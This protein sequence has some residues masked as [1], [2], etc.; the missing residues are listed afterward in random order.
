MTIADADRGAAVA[1]E[2]IQLELKAEW[3][4]NAEECEGV[5]QLFVRLEAFEAEEREGV[6][7]PAV[8]DGE[9]G[10]DL[11]DEAVLVGSTSA[12]SLFV[13]DKVHE[14]RDLAE[15]YAVGKAP[16]KNA[17]LFREVLELMFR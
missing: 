1:T 9:G 17:D 7:G 3:E 11:G 4:G 6:S 16:D 12:D 10:L 8:D 2:Q 13:G 15:W 14:V 5:E